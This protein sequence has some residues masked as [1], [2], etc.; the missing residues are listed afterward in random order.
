MSTFTAPTL[1]DRLE[2]LSLEVAIDRLLHRQTKSWGCFRV[3]EET[4]TC[5]RLEVDHLP[6]LSVQMGADGYTYKAWWGVKGATAV[7]VRKRQPK[8]ITPTRPQ[9]PPQS[10]PQSQSPALRI[11]SSSLAGAGASPSA[12]PKA[13]AKA[14][15]PAN[16]PANAPT[17]TPLTYEIQWRADARSTQ[18]QIVVNVVQAIESRIQQLID[19]LPDEGIKPRVVVTQLD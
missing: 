6:P 17:A 1:A 16:A 18:K 11:Q 8:L 13:G 19:E 14:N 9:S 2:T 5:Y 12:N 4:R 3:V 10:R 7:V 15:V